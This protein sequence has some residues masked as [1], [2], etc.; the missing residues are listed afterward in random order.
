M[1]RRMGRALNMIERNDDP[2]DRSHRLRNVFATPTLCALYNSIFIHT[3]DVWDFYEGVHF[4]FDQG[5]H[6]TALCRRRSGRGRSWAFCS[7]IHEPLY[8]VKCARESSAWQMRNLVNVR[9]ANIA[10][11]LM[12][13]RD[14]RRLYFV[15]EQCHVTLGQ[16]VDILLSQSS[17]NGSWDFQV[18]AII[19][20]VLIQYHTTMTI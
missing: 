10:L 7:T 20:Q 8:T 1:C 6:L 16:V 11:P 14:R 2:S 4:C 17:T 5:D 18:A 12:A 3:A 15:Y 9:H 13:F 19:R